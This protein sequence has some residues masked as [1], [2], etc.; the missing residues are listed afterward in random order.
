MTRNIVIKNPSPRMIQVFDELRERKQKQ[1]K[2]LSEK[3]QGTFT[4]V[5]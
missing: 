1:I 3:K 2:K 4:I 5:V